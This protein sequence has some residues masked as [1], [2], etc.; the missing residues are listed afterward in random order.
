[1]GGL[2]GGGVTSLPGGPDIRETT[3]T[4]TLRGPAGGHRPAPDLAGHLATQEGA[5]RGGTGVL[6]TPPRQHPDVA[7]PARTFVPGGHRQ[8]GQDPHDLRWLGGRGQ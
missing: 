5:E 2:V 8:G 4:T 1:M 6:G 7:V 3:P